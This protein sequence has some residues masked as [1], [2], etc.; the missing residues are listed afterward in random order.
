MPYPT[1]AT[2]A[3]INL[4]GNCKHPQPSTAIGA[5]LRFGGKKSYCN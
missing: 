3:F 5:V 4:Y 1:R 2:Q